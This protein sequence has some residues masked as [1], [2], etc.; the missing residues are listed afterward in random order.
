VV[1][2][3][4]TAQ[5]EVDSSNENVLALAWD[6]V[7]GKGRHEHC[8]T[9]PEEVGREGHQDHAGDHHL[10]MREGEVVSREVEHLY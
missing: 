7:H 3:Y 1:Y 10:D 8:A 9:R 6:M 5:E 2:S 4:Y